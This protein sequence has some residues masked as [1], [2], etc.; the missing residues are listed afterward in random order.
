M[1]VVHTSQVYYE[2]QNTKT[3]FMTTESM[4]KE[5]EKRKLKIM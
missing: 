2:N 4:L 1:K 5:K 3:T